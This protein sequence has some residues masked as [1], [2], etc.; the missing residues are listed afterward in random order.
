MAETT[1]PDGYGNPPR[2]ATIEQV[3]A[4][5]SV[6]MLHPE[7]QKRLKGLMIAS[8]G[9]LGVGGA[10]RS[11]QQQESVF[12]QRHHQVS[13]GGCCVYQGKRYQLNTGMA[14]AAPPGRSFHETVVYGY[15]AAVDFVGDLRWFALNC[16]RYGLEQATWGGEDWH[17]QFTEFPHSVA[18]W[19]KLGSPQPQKWVLPGQD[20]DT[21]FGADTSVY[22]DGL[23][24]PTPHGVAFQIARA[25][26]GNLSDATCAK[27]LAWAKANK[28][29]F[30]G[31]HFAYPVASHPA[32]GQANAFHKGVGGDTSIPCVVDWEADSDDNCHANGGPQK[33]LWA[34]VLGVVTA[35][36]GLGH[37]VTLVYAP[38]WYWTEAGQPNMV[39]VGVDLISADFGLKPWP[40]GTPANIYNVRGG[41]NGTGWQAY[42]GLTPTFWQ[43]TETATW[44]NR[45]NVDFNAYRGT[46]TDLGRWF[47]TWTTTPPPQP[48]PV[49]EDDNMLF[50]SRLDS[51]PNLIVVGDGITSRRIRADEIDELTAALSKGV[52]PQF[53]DPTVVGAPVIRD[54]NK[55]PKVSDDWQQ[56]FGIETTESVNQPG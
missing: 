23:V 29:P 40:T 17:G 18:Q 47:T 36:R 39:G 38:K 49:L 45:T 21:V 31:Y 54:I 3:F 19:Q 25:S 13:S 56:L 33:T 32:A 42:G 55:L 11:T 35:I 37:K 22:D 27:T 9:K 51:N 28:V 14:H 52:G 50:I 5:S 2:Q 44:G 6:Q 4:R 53:H 1:F 48:A 8:G 20:V 15:S 30:A 24:P 12:L 26:I 46:T 7:Y 43:F 16:E 34:D 10:G 41:D